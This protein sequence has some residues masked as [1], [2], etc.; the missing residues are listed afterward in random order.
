M[1]HYIALPQH[2]VPAQTYE[3]F[4]RGFNFCVPPE[5]AGAAVHHGARSFGV[6]EEEDEVE[7]LLERIITQLLPKL[8]LKPP[9]GTHGFPAGIFSNDCGIPQHP[10]HNH[11]LQGAPP[12]GSAPRPDCGGC[13]LFPK[14]RLHP[15]SQ[16]LSPVRQQQ[17]HHVPPPTEIAVHVPVGPHRKT[18]PA[19]LRPDHASDF[20]QIRRSV[21]RRGGAPRGARP[22]VPEED[23]EDPAPDIVGCFGGA[24]GGSVRVVPK[25]VI[26][27]LRVG[28][29]LFLRGIGVA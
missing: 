28:A 3:A 27:P 26:E 14:Y 25:V 15:D 5:K 17:L 16:P 19:H 18:T 9:G 22:A 10:V 11:L 13:G 20:Q 29:A 12:L 2:E 23:P 24:V 1:F 21:Q 6:I 4:P 8:L 7:N